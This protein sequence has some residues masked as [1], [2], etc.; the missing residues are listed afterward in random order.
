MKKLHLVFENAFLHT[1]STHPMHAWTGSCALCD[2]CDA[3]HNPGEDE[4]NAGGLARLVQYNAMVLK[5][6]RS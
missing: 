3:I 4:I 5:V 6:D 2:V 1:Q